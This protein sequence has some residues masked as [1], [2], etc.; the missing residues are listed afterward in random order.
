MDISCSWEGAGGKACDVR[1]E[2]LA[3]RSG[4]ARFRGGQDR[5]VLS[6]LLPPGRLVLPGRRRYQRG[7]VPQVVKDPDNVRHRI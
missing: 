4:V 3:G 5:A 2:Q 7:L 6:S 1:G